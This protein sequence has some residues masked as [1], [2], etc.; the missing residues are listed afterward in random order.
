MTM[1]LWITALILVSLF[2]GFVLDGAGP[3]T[4]SGHSESQEIAFDCNNLEIDHCS[5]PDN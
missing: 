5:N 3:I 4:D 1:K 2:S